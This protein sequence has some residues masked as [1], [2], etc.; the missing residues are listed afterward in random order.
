MLLLVESGCPPPPAPDM[1]FLRRTKMWPMPIAHFLIRA[2][3]GRR[4]DMDP[5][6]EQVGA[7]R[8]LRE[9]AGQASHVRAGVEQKAVLRDRLRQERR[10]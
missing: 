9:Q 4:A 2:C 3:G 8:P 1:P 6:Q 5:G 7:C 10:G